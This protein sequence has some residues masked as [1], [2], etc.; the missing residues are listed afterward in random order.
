MFPKPGRPVPG[1][2]GGVRLVCR[3]FGGSGPAVLLLHGLAR[4]GGSG[5]APRASSPPRTASWRSTRAGMDA[6]SAVRTT[7]RRRLAGRTQ[8]PSWTAGTRTRRSSRPISRRTDS[9]ASGGET[10]AS[11]TSARDGRCGSYRRAGSWGE[12][13]VQGR[14]AAAG[15]A[16]AVPV[17]SGGS[18]LLRRPV[19]RGSG[20]GRTGSKARDGE[21]WPRFDVDVLVATLEAASGRSYWRD[22]SRSGCPTLVVPPGKGMLSANEADAMVAA[23][24]AAR[25]VRSR[26]PDTTCPWI[27]PRSGAAPC[28]RS[29]VSSP[30]RSLT[31]MARGVT[32][33]VGARNDR[34]DA[35][36]PGVVDGLVVHTNEAAD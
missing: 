2:P 31:Q 22:W 8:H 17:A 12:H 5:R 33:S 15:L 16:R 30:R 1:R 14:R 29:C 23:L 19:A 10:R 7:C 27:A 34:L 25:L 3:D 18:G 26:K 20:R 32:R 36:A 13:G 4:H 9:A 28:C 21:L 24:P 35:V 6:V 11:R